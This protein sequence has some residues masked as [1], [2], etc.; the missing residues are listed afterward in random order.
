MLPSV[1]QPPL[2]FLDVDGVLIPFR[3]RPTT[4]GRPSTGG[5]VNA[6]APDG[7]GNPLLDRL[8]LDDGRRL[9]ALGC[10]LVWATT[11]MA[12]ANEIIAPRLGLPALPVVEWPDSGEEPEHGLHWKTV[13]L[14]RWAA[15]RPFVWLDDEITD[16][17]RRWVAANHPGQALLHR[18]DPFAGLTDAAFAAVHQWLGQGNDGA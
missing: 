11:W 7:W 6:E 4:R 13:F 2:I 12:E 10:Q 17:D 1:A 16:A 9:L 3:G 8:D 5:E 15:G 18:V 14:T